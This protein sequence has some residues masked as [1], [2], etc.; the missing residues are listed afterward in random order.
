[1]LI[2]DVFIWNPEPSTLLLINFI[3]D[4]ITWQRAILYIGG[5]VDEEDEED[6]DDEVVPEDYADEDEEEGDGADEE[7]D[8]DDE[9]A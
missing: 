3:N 8:D 1:M 2:N 6:D 9:D 5:D 7:D 4:I